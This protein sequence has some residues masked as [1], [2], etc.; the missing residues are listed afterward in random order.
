M[1][2]DEDEDEDNDGVEDDSAGASGAV[3]GGGGGIIVGK[4]EL[5]LSMPRRVSRA[6]CIQPDPSTD[7]DTWDDDDDDDGKADSV[8]GPMGI[9]ADVRTIVVDVDDDAS[10]ATNELD[11]NANEAAE[12]DAD[13]DDADGAEAADGTSNS[14]AGSSVTTGGGGGGNWLRG[15]SGRDAAGAG[16]ATVV[17]DET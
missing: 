2:D 1:D 5:E 8:G 6:C 13:A 12:T 11:G 10:L 7:C 15:S 9:N 16:A 3:A 4:F 14:I 17:V